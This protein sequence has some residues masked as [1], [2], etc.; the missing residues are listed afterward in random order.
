MEKTLGSIEA[1]CKGTTD[2]VVLAG[3]DNKNPE[4]FVEAIGNRCHV[5]IFKWSK[6]KM[7]LKS[8]KK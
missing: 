8:N 6:V 2:A 7:N 1:T 5:N 3:G 4:N